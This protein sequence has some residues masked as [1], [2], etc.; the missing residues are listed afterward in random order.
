MIL[1]PYFIERSDMWI[2]L[3]IFLSSGGREAWHIE[4]EKDKA[5]LKM[6]KE[7]GFPVLNLEKTT[8]AIYAH[9][10]KS[11]DLSSFYT[12]TE[13]NPET[14]EDDVWRRLT[15]PVSLWSCPIFRENFFKAAN[16]PLGVEAILN[17]V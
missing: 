10:D 8:Q 9:I 16:L 7:N 14:S 4:P 12:W 1:V 2:T 15:M 11:I 6:L 5:I 3:N 13:V 17:K